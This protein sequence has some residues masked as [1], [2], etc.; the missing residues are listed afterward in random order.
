MSIRPAGL[1]ALVFA[2]FTLVVAGCG[3]GDNETEGTSGSEPTAA[4][5]EADQGETEEEKAKEEQEAEEAGG[6]SCSEVGEIDGE[7]S[8]QPP[9]DV[10]ILE[11]AK[12]YESEGPF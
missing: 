2:G 3:S 1:V 6:K 12:V 9:S 8:D 7:P 4:A 11:G 5:T 10:A